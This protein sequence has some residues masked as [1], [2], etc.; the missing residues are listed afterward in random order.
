MVVGLQRDTKEG[1]RG[2]G[3]VGI[4]LWT[5]CILFVVVNHFFVLWQKEILFFE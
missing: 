5:Q 4:T 2:Y 1:Q 3:N